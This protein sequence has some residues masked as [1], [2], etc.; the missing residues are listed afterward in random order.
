MNALPNN[1]TLDYYKVNSLLRK[2]LNTVMAE[3]NE[4][5]AAKYSGLSEIMRQKALIRAEECRDTYATIID[6]LN[7]RY[8]ELQPD[9]NK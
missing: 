6:E 9:T 2:H 7:A 1:A 4:L 3:C 8:Y 5:R